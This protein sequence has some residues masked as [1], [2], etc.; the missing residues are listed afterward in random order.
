MS[1]HVPSA[2]SNASFP[3]PSAGQVVAVGRESNDIELYSTNDWTLLRRIP[4]SE[5]AALTCVTWAAASSGS[6]DSRLFSA[7]LDGQ[8]IEYDLS[9][10]RPKTVSDAFG[11]AVW[12]LAR[13][14]AP[15]PSSPERYALGCDDGAIR[16]FTVESG[17]DGMQ[18]SKSLPR[19]EGRILSLAWHPSG[20][21]LVAGD[22]Q[23]CIRCWDVEAGRELLRITVG[24][25]SGKEEICVWALTVLADGT[26][27]SGDANGNTQF[28]DGEFGT[29]IQSFR[30][31]GADVMCLAAT[32]AGSMVF[33]AGVDHQVAAFQRTDS[34][35]LTPEAAAQNPELTEALRVATEQGKPWVYLTSKRP[36]SHDV[37]AL[38]MIAPPAAPGAPEPKSMMVSG[39][40]DAQLFAYTALQFTKQH[41]VRVVKDPQRPRIS[42]CMG[43]GAGPAGSR[44]VS[45]EPNGHGRSNGVATTSKPA[46]QRVASGLLGRNAAPNALPRVLCMQPQH[47]DV[48]RLGRPGA[49]VM[50]VAVNTP[51]LSSPGSRQQN[52]DGA[53]PSRPDDGGNGAPTVVNGV[54]SPDVV[55][56]KRARPEAN[57][58]VP[59]PI[60]GHSNPIV[61]NE[62]DPLDLADAPKHLAR[63][64]SGR[65][66]F[67]LSAALSPSGLLVAFSDTQRVRLYALDAASNDVTKRRVAPA[68]PAAA[69]LA[70][71]SDSKHL[72]AASACGTVTVLDVDTG[73][74]ARTFEEARGATD[75]AAT[76]LAAVA[77]PV[78]SLQCS[79]D[80]QWL[81]AAGPQE[82]HLFDLEG[83][84]YHGRLPAV[85]VRSSTAF[86]FMFVVARLF[87]SLIISIHPFFCLSYR[88]VSC[89]YKWCACFFGFCW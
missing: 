22:S 36:H 13:E 27:V 16:I 37:R 51:P 57:G 30:Q 80:G 79:V 78:T 20:S 49:T 32:P 76:S 44:G 5:D 34:L 9:T 38:C 59:V 56:A 87:L 71:S 73:N 35:D 3:F 14:P 85:E 50:G 54:T 1:S 60:D 33:S 15:A 7:G 39:G 61:P 75:R 48:W 6:Q 2:I 29:R 64:K 18:Y 19:V 23:G 31:H 62:F 70:F 47:V 21:V 65:K 42:V 43:A 46:L 28:W 88:S 45:A 69:Q 4:G 83:M 67:L 89:V 8:I 72:I 12:S 86:Y 41:P 66:G 82:V 11:G 68:V 55:G 77:A 40:V 17:V 84:R 25:G 63:I 81:A 26:I 24:D 74:V 58:D 10:L 52:G 53:G